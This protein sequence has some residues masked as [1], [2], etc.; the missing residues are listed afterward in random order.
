MFANTSMN[1]RVSSPAGYCLHQIQVS[2]TGLFSSP[3]LT[4]NHSRP[5]SQQNWAHLHFMRK[6]I[7]T[8]TMDKNLCI[9]AP[10]IMRK[11]A[12]DMIWIC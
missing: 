3:I 10:K 4:V 5:T 6:R 11:M 1:Y 8:L 2:Y 9:Q 7:F 12:M